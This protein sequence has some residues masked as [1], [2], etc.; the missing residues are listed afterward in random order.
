[1]YSDKKRLLSQPFLSSVDG[2]I[3]I[4]PDENN[5]Q[6]ADTENISTLDDFY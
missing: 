2:S 1:M 4:S 3:T 5:Q 6:P